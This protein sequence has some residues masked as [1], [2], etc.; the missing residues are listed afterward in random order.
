M[1]ISGSVVSSPES[2]V[3]STLGWRKPRE[4]DGVMK[5]RCGYGGSLL[6]I[7][8]NR[9]FLCLPNVVLSILSYQPPRHCL[10]NI[11]DKTKVRPRGKCIAP[12][13]PDICK[14]PIQSR[15]QP[16]LS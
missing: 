5:L 6:L 14:R 7:T 4:L 1:V 15:K 16:N 11:R 13:M 9:F 10:S 8:P 3:G 2:V 12:Y